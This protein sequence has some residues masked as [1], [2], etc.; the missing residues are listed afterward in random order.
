M[1]EEESTFEKQRLKLR[2][3]ARP[4]VL[5]VVRATAHSWLT[6]AGVAPPVARDLVLAI[7]EACA[8][9]VEHSG[10]RRSNCVE[11]DGEVDGSELVLQVRDYGSWRNPC[12]PGDRGRGLLII[13]AL[14]DDLDVVRSED[15]TELRFT[16]RVR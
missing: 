16:R 7:N 2:L 4:E 6:S 1:T 14:V 12:A 5:P 10:A 11:V 15:G 9:A 8:N 13:R 3:P